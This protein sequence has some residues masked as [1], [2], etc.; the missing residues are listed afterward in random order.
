MRIA[1]VSS[2]YPWPPSVGGVET[3]VRN[4]SEELARRGHDVHVVT[5]PFDV[6]TMNRVS[7]YGV[8]ERD[9]VT[10]H[11]LRTGRLR[12]GYA[13]LLDGLKKAVERI[14]PEI[15]HSHNLHPHL[16][17]LAKWKH[18]FGYKLL[19]ELHYPTVNF[20]FYIQEFLSPFAVRLLKWRR[21]DID[22]FI[23]HTRMEKSW[24]VH[25]VGAEDDQVELLRPPMIRSEYFSA[26]YEK[27]SKIPE[28]LLY[29]GRVVPKKGLHILIKALR[30]VGSASLTVAGTADKTYLAKLMK[31]V[32]RLGLKGRVK[33]LGFVT[34]EEKISMMG[35]HDV[36]VCPTLADYHPIVLLEAQALGTPV[37][38]TR[39]GAIPEIILDGQTGL[40]VEPGNEPELAK[41]MEILLRNEVMRSEFSRRAR[42]F[43]KNFTAEKATDKLEALYCNVLS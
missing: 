24:L 27:C 35:V 36:F 41:A 22:S 16:F 32:E 28:S 34:E 2:Y 6:T 7:E 38:A 30:L 8:E 14:R 29:V 31:L 17:Q 18:E 42:E 12:V 3:I 33:F 13:R 26:N 10:V 39:V 9:G 37:I 4:V 19:A 23:A 43:A 40:L 11:K 25:A 5:T 21:S 15:V 1:I 20:D